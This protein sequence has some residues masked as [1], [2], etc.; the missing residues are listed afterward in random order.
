MGIWRDFFLG[1]PL[2]N[3]DSKNP[4]ACDIS[5]KPAEVKPKSVFDG[6]HNLSKKELIDLAGKVDSSGCTYVSGNDY[7]QHK[8]A[9]RKMIKEVLEYKRNDWETFS[10]KEIEK[11]AHD[12]EN[13]PTNDVVSHLLAKSFREALKK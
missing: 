7:P 5:K 10:K 8:E 9:L 4:E 11:L 12:L 13:K 1:Q 6:G 3:K 2:E